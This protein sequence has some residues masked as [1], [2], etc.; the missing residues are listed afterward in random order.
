MHFIL[1]PLGITLSVFGIIV[2]ILVIWI[3][4]LEVKLKKFLVGTG[5][6]NISDSFVHIDTSLKDL[7]QFRKELEEYLR[8]VEKR[9]RQ[10]IQGV[11]TVRF[12]PFKGTGAGGN[13]SFATA[14]LNEEG[15]G[16]VLSSLYSRDR[17]SI[18]SKPLSA[19]KSEF[20][21]TKEER[22]AI[23]QARKDLGVA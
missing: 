4:R 3:I 15:D 16:V 7:A 9:L 22:D 18:F 5:A 6:K 13:Q 12:N 19:Y 23:A 20:E 14:F 2:L 11:H 21:L 10:S 1:T 8:S 17:V